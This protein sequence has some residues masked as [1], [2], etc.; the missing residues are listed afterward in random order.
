MEVDSEG[1]EEGRSSVYRLKLK[2]RDIYHISLC[3][4]LQE[5]EAQNILNPITCG[6][7]EGDLRNRGVLE[8]GDLKHFPLNV[9]GVPSFD[10]FVESRKQLFSCFSKR[11]LKGVIE[12]LDLRD[13]KVEILAYASSYIS[14]LNEVRGGLAAA[15]SDGQ[16]NNLLNVSQR[17]ESG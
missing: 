5:V 14:L 2:N 8:V 7:W 1:W 17:S 4:V 12:V 3:P 15:T 16:I 11:D 9:V 6:A 10:A 13:F